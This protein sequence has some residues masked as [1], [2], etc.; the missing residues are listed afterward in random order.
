M[1]KDENLKR[2]SLLEVPNEKSGF[3]PVS[4]LDPKIAEK[5]IPPHII[6]DLQECLKDCP[7]DQIPFFETE[8]KRMDM[9]FLMLRAYNAGYARCL[10]NH[11]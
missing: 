8:K 6:L 3:I 10:K 2:V 9:V 5:Y 1:S 7:S 11:G 4:S